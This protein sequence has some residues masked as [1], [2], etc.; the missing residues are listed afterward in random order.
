ML[1]AALLSILHINK[2]DDF[3]LVFEDQLFAIAFSPFLS[4]NKH[5]NILFK[6]KFPNTLFCQ[7]GPET[8]M[9]AF[10]CLNYKIYF[11]ISDGACAM[12]AGLVKWIMR[13]LLVQISDE[14]PASR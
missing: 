1:S 14:A 4:Q 6:I 7:F 11:S 8:S 10:L 3:F 9:K 13:A 5:K 2:P 12:H